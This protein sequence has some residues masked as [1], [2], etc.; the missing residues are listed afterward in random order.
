[1]HTEEHEFHPGW[2][3][4]LGR[5]LLT[6]P[7]ATR[8]QLHEAEGRTRLGGLRHRFFLGLGQSWFVRSSQFNSESGCASNLRVVRGSVN[9]GYI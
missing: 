3:A 9:H 2:R 1:M 6:S 5:V 4:S 8:Y 7:R